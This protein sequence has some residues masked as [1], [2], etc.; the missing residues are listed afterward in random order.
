MK[1]ETLEKDCYYHV[2]YREINSCAIFN[3]EENMDYF[4]KLASKHLYQKAT[5][6]AYCLMNNH[7]HFAIQI[8]EHSKVVSQAF[9]N[10]FNAYSKAFNKQ[11]NRTG[12]LFERPYKR[13]KIK[14]ENYLKKLVLY[15][16]KNPQN[17]KIINDFKK[18]KFTSY[19]HFLSSKNSIITTGKDYVINLFNNLRNFK[20]AHQTDLSGFQNLT[21]LTEKNKILKNPFLPLTIKQSLFMKSQK[22][23]LGLFAILSLQMKKDS[24]HS[25]L[26]RKHK[27]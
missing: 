20:D 21:G 2:Y 1:I 8:T 24:L 25:S 5:I 7:F 17:H 14:D 6:L 16:H 19:Q 23:M 3:N 12:T 27:I 10:L 18:Y 22:K 11:N 9:S 4:L 26:K 13:I 15:I